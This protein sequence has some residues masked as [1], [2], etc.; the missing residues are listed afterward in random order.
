MP[1]MLNALT[2]VGVIVRRER[3]DAT[4]SAGRAAN[5]TRVPATTATTN[6]TP[7]NEAMRRH[8]GLRGSGALEIA[9]AG[10]ARLAPLSSTNSAVEMSATRRR[11]SLV[12]QL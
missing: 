4:E 7:V 8:S 12:R 6:T 10:G 1:L 3:R 2:G 11:R 5:H 9:P